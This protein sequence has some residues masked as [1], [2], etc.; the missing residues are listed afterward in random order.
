VKT[1]SV[2]WQG[3]NVGLANA[4]K[5]LARA[6]F[7]GTVGLVLCA[8]C[9]SAVT[10]SPIP[11][12]LPPTA[13]AHLSTHQGPVVPLTLPP[14]WTATFTPS[15]TNTLTPTPITPTAT[16]TPLPSLA[17]LCASFTLDYSFDD[18][19][20]FVWGDTITMLYG[21]PY[22]IVRDPLTNNAVPV[23]IR[24][25]ATHADS[26]ENLGVQSDGGQTSGMQLDAERL[27][28]PGYYTWK[29]FVYADS[30]G[31]RCLHEGNFYVYPSE[32][33]TEPTAEVTPETE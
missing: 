23:R 24:F 3:L 15:P 8:A 1:F 25:L 2:C 10:P 29:L 17:Q 21:T 33:T 27:T 26:G 19:H 32:M 7:P 13:T 28:T 11:T 20:V 18:G 16:S 4:R 22:K 9:T 14:T 12:A 31:E 6:L 5:R 30:F